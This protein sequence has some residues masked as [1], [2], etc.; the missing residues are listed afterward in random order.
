MFDSIFWHQFHFMRPLWLLTFLPLLLLF[1]LNWR[2]K[3]E[4]ELTL[5]GLPPHII[6][7]L[8]VGESGWRK[9]LPLKLLIVTAVLGVLVAAGPTWTHQP[10]PFGTDKAPLVVVLDDSKSMLETD[11][12]PSRLTRAKQKILDLIKLRDGGRNALVVVSGSGHVAMPLTQ[13]IDV[14]KPLLYAVNPDIMPIKGKFQEKALPRVQQV[15]NQ[16]D[17]PDYAGTVLLVTDSISPT[18]EKAFAKFFAEKDGKK[19]PQLL[20]YG[21][22][23]KNGVAAQRYD[24]DSL[25]TLADDADGHFIQQSVD[26]SDLQWIVK[27]ISTHMQISTDSAQPW[28][29][30]GY[31]LIIAMAILFLLWFRRGWTV[32]WC[33]ALVAVI[34]LHTPMAHAQMYSK[35]KLAEMAAEKQAFVDKESGYRWGQLW[36]TPDQQGM[37]FVK[38]GDYKRAANR[39]EDPMWK[40]TAYFLAE[41]YKNAQIYYQQVHTLNG[42]I[43]VANSLAYQR[44]YPMARDYFQKLAKE[45]PDNKKIKHNLQLMI[46]IIAEIDQFS[47]S[48]TH[49]LDS[50]KEVSQE[51]PKD[52]PQT[53]NGAKEKTNKNLMMK[54][55]YTAEELLKNNKL[56]EAWMKRVQG[57]PSKFLASKFAM[58]LFEEQDQ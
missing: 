10:S 32:R 29:D 31:G 34:G 58:E 47:E 36:L 4:Q 9:F 18:S 21:M 50:A 8:T 44:K 28:K 14:F 6:K 41:D 17:I 48:Q 20:V 16:S 42:K 57:D 55:V 30:Q 35:S 43:G 53:S 39:F 15:L 5:K 2:N 40:A 12:A 45:Y 26:N 49:Q 54:K 11:V 19:R 3:K 37:L 38:L 56:N 22:G 33:I 46:N 25:E 24:Q 51:L 13:D 52:Q 23:V 1:Y 27:K 7:A